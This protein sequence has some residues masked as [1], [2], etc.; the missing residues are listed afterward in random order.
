M[1][2]TDIPISMVPGRGQAL[3]RHADSYLRAL[4]GR[5][6]TLRLADPSSGDTSSQL[7]ITPP[8][9]EDVQIAPAVVH[10]INPNDDGTRRLQVVLSAKAL[11]PIADS[12]GVTDIATW[13]MQSQGVF[14][15]GRL[16]P[17]R[18]VTS[19][20]FADVEC[21]YFLTATE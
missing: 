6:I 10:V 16:M 9:S 12:Y 8:T 21:L 13:L 7:G 2:E 5:Q 20:S 18:E 1:P 19:N 14:Y 3:R 11:Q 4:G 17:I 15:R